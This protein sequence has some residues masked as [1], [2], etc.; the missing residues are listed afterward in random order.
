MTSYD[1]IDLWRQ[2]RLLHEVTYRQRIVIETLQT[3][4]DRAG[5]LEQR[6]A[7]EKSASQA[8]SP[9]HADILRL[10]DEKIQHLMK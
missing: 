9:T 3:L 6:L 5:L 1:E 7:L 2:I 8:Y 10:I 4:S